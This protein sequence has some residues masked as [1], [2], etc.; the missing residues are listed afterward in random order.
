[1]WAKWRLP[2]SLGAILA[3]IKLKSLN[4][5]IMET[6]V[7]LLLFLSICLEDHPCDM[8]FLFLIT[9]T[10][11][12]LCVGVI[13]FGSVR[14][15]SKKVTKPNFIFFEKKN[16]NRTE[17]RSNRPVSVRFGFLG[18]KL[19]VWLGFSGFG[20]VFSILARFLR[21]GSV[22]RFGSGFFSGFLSVSV[23]FFRFFG[24]KTETEPN[25]PVF[26]KI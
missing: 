7:F 3:K 6:I 16:R 20:S 12:S 25:R 10:V 15:L 14:F 2:N 17:T 22:F 5:I 8:G 1:M 9:I 26:S 13:I 21:F 18:Q 4:T 11:K 23:W 24:Y 19:P